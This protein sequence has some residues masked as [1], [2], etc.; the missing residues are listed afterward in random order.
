MGINLIGLKKLPY[1]VLN[2]SYKKRKKEK[3]IGNTYY[4]DKGS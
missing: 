2:R 4:Y 3:E 1:K